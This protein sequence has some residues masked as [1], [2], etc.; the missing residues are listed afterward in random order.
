MFVRRECA[1]FAGALW[2][3]EDGL[4]AERRMN[5]LRSTRYEV[6]TA[7]V[8][9]SR[10]CSFITSFLILTLLGQPITCMAF[11]GIS[12]AEHW[13]S[14]RRFVDDH[15]VVRCGVVHAH[16]LMSQV[17]PSSDPALS[18]VSLAMY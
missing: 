18:Q 7:V 8:C 16:G 13:T 11:A 1:C 3:G 10:G 12:Q 2:A 4:Q 9:V 15:I 17:G 5:G 6:S 14:V